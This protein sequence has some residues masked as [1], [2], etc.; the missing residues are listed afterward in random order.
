LLVSQLE[1]TIEFQDN[2]PGTKVVLSI[3]HVPP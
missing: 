2:A 1:G 3:P